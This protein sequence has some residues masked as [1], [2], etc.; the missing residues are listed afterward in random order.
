VESLFFQLEAS[1]KTFYASLYLQQEGTIPEKEAKVFAS[2]E[3]SD[4]K[5][6]L[7]DQKSVYLREKRLLEL[8]MK[9]YEAEYQTYKVE[10]EA[11]R[12]HG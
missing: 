4:F 3:W 1:E 5:K 11:I 7:S 6:G 8:K 10:S 12:K 9:A 2:K